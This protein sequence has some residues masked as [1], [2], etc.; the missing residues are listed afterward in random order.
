MKPLA[1]VAFLFLITFSFGQ[2]TQ[3]DRIVVNV[4]ANYKPANIELIKNKNKISSFSSN[5]GKLTYRG[6]ETA[7]YSVLVS[8]TRQIIA[9][10]DSVFVQNGQLLE[11][12]IMLDGTCLY[13]YPADSTPICPENHTDN[14]IPIV[15]GLVA[16]TNGSKNKEIHL[17]GCIVSD[18]DPK[19]Y[20]KAHQ[21]TF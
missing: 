14:I 11:L 4:T 15:Y 19:Y 10:T 2:I 16:R 17:G 13:D 18:C 3:A 12:N 5:G 7:Y 9:K 8:G 1:T 20:C 21:K 6:L